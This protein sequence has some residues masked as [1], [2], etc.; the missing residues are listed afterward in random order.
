MECK[1]WIN[2]IGALVPVARWLLAGLAHNV[3]MTDM[4]VQTWS[5]IPA[6]QIPYHRATTGHLRSGSACKQS[7]CI[8]SMQNRL[9]KF[10]CF[11]GNMLKGTERQC[12]SLIQQKNW[13]DSKLKLTFSLCHKLWCTFGVSWG[14]FQTYALCNCSKRL[15]GWS[16]IKLVYFSGL[17]GRGLF[18]TT[19]ITIQYN[20]IISLNWIYLALRPM[21]I[22]NWNWKTM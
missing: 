4:K 12:K 10:N 19:R 21:N 7:T 13:R 1:K 11:K 16:V 5:S 20:Q 15:V 22:F 3:E 18:Y 2:D 14:A 6:D 8:C 17:K 9:Q